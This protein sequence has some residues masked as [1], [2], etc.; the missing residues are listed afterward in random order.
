MSPEYTIFVEPVGV[1][2]TSE[3]ASQT[4]STSLVTKWDSQTSHLVTGLDG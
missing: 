3:S 4:V 2:P 1:E